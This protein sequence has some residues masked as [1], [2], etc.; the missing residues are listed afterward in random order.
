MKVISDPAMNYASAFTETTCGCN[1]FWWGNAEYL[2][3]W[4]QGMGV[5]ALATSGSAADPL[6]GALGQPGTN[7]LFGNT[8]LNNGARSGGRFTLG[9]WLDPCRCCGIE[10]TYLTLGNQDTTFN[11]SNNTVAVLARPFLN[12][13]TAA[14]DA[15]LIANPGVVSGTLGIV[16]TTEFQ[17]LEV[18]YRQVGSRSC[19][20]QLD[21]LI[22][23]RFAELQDRRTHQ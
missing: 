22:G 5:P 15:R 7:T 14:Q 8:R 17:S 2:L 23:Y 4:T 18:L 11:A 10:V 19:G 6:P 21:Y 3:W 12:T 13:V 9:Q 1:P 16:A 20:L